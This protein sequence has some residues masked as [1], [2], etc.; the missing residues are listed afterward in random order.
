LISTHT[1]SRFF[2]IIQTNSRLTFTMQKVNYGG[3]NFYT[4]SKPVAVRIN[5]ST[6]GAG[7]A[8][9]PVQ[10]D[11]IRPVVV[12]TGRGKTAGRVPNL[13]RLRPDV[14]EEIKSLVD[15]PLYLTIELALRHYAEHLRAKPAGTVEMVKASDLE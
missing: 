1:F 13:V 15:G 2:D 7:L 12:I 3:A 9:I 14:V 8:P 4:L 6:P 5:A 10:K 11:E